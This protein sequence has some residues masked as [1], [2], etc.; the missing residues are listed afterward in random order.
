MVD[1]VADVYMKEIQRGANPM[2]QSSE[3]RRIGEE[4]VLKKIRGI[5]D[6][7]ANQMP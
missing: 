2:E 6:D 7:V 4:L 3:Y 1:A 5:L